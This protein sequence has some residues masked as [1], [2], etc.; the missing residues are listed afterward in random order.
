M[1]LHRERGRQ[2]FHRRKGIHSRR[3]N[4]RATWPDGPLHRRAWVQ[5]EAVLGRAEFER[6][7]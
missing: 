3:Q 2:T 5:V 6:S 4:R 7:R 1:R